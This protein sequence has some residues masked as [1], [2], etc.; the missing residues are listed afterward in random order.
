M[1]KK[2]VKI[3]KNT[4]LLAQE[5]AEIFV[6]LSIQAIKQRGIFTVVLSGG[7]TPRV[8]FETLASSLFSSRVEW[9]KVHFFWG[10]ERLVPPNDPNS[11]YNLA[12][13]TLLAPLHIPEENIFRI[14]GEK[15]GSE[16][17]AN[18]RS[19]LKQYF[20]S[21]EFPCFDLVYLGLGIDG[22]TASLFPDTKAIQETNLAVVENYIPKLDS[23]RVTLTFPVF[24]NARN[25]VFLV[26]GSEKAKVVASVLEEKDSLEKLPSQLIKPVEGTLT[27]MLD[28]TAAQYVKV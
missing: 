24:N 13:E 15:V 5:A 25:V 17:A 7:N 11:N 6:K 26:S 23:F 10:D 22:H 12:K 27:W 2:I 28:S 20:K 21:N 8:L 3:F 1:T 9:P 19:V 4:Q 18:Y 14:L 16:A